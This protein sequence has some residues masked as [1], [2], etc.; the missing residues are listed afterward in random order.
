MSEKVLVLIRRTESGKR[1]FFR[2]K[3]GQKRT[4][5]KSILFQT[6]HVKSDFR[7]E[8]FVVIVAL[9]VLYCDVEQVIVHHHILN[10][11]SSIAKIK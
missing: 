8:I 7:Q 10:F 11:I 2:C 4:V 9:D 5:W 6:V 1:D 3:I